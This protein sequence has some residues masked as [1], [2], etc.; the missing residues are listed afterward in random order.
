MAI[1][2]AKGFLV[3]VVIVVFVWV[4]VL[5]YRYLVFREVW[6]DY[7]NRFGGKADTLTQKK[8]TRHWKMPAYD[9]YFR[10]A[11][12]S[13]QWASNE[14]IVFVGLC[15][16][17]G[18]HALKMWLPVVEE[19]GSHFKDYRV[20]IVENDSR[21]G[22]RK[23]LLQQAKKDP[24]FI[25][26]CDE[27]RPPNTLTCNLGVRSVRT[28]Q[29]KEKNLAKRVATL[30]RF[31]Q[32][33]WSFVRRELADY[34]FM[35]VVDWDLEGQLSVPGFFHGLYHARNS[36][37]VACNSFTMGKDHD[38]YFYD[39]YPLLNNHRCDHLASNKIR[40]DMRV[41][42]IMSDKLLTEQS[43]YPLHVESAFGG[44]ALYNLQNIT[45]KDPDYTKPACPI[46]CEHTTFH[47]GLVVHI[48]PWMT[49]FISKNRH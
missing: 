29:E 8:L 6:A 10:N 30:G 18:T 31:R 45:P 16:D 47:R 15:Q 48:D 3:V 22:T 19:I 1:D 41:N 17:H 38:F 9:A 39:T 4:V 43:V 21:D 34:D 23:V 25:I 32:V 20:V 24:R 49:F 27:K 42:K 28:S 11:Q 14:K 35:C 44:L 40:E 33:Y 36:D 5:V 37:V 7:S 12:H 13:M 26:L 2:L 46:E